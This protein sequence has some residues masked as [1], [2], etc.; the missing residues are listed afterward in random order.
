M[1]D[2]G[3]RWTLDIDLALRAGACW[4]TSKPSPNT[5]SHSVHIDQTGGIVFFTLELW[6]LMRW[7]PGAT[8]T[9]GE[10]ETARTLLAH[11]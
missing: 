8:S 7:P 5:I 6:Q 10:D 1:A 4:S 11:P 9:D 3:R 2:W